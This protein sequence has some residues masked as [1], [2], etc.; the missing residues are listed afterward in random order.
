MYA[1]VA[2]LII[3]L[4]YG[5]ET[6][7]FRFSNKENSDEPAVFSVVLKSIVTSSLLFIILCTVFRIPIAN[8]LMYPN[9]S[10]YVVWFALIVG[11]DAISSIPLAR[12]RSKQKPVRFAMVNLT[13]VFVNIALNLF[14]IAYCKVQFDG[15]NSNWLIDT[16]YNPEIGVGY[17]FIA[18][19]VASIVKL[20]MLS[21]ELL[22]A[23]KSF[24]KKLLYSLMIYSSPLLVAGLAGMV[25]ETLD[26]ILLKYILIDSLGEKATMSQLGIYGACYKV[27]IIIT[28]FIQAF[29][30]AAEPFFFAQHKASPS[31]EIYARV[32]NYFVAVCTSIFLGVMLF[33]DLIK[34]FIP[35]PDYWVGLQ[36][37]P[38]LLMA[39][40]CLGIYFNQSIW[41]K[42]TDKTSFGAY[43][44]IGGAL[45]TITLNLLFIP[46]LGYVGSAWATL[47]VYASMVI[48]SY[49]F[50]QIHFP[51]PYNLL[52]VLGYIG[53]AFIV[54]Y[55]GTYL[56]ITFPQLH[57]IIA[58]V[59]VTAFMSTLFLIEKKTD[60]T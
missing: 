15:G 2:F 48:V 20:L 28:L 8:W 4:T 34:Y 12:L 56:Q 19:L 32:M 1:Y 51:I 21:P 16:F 44:A 25:N 57:W 41:Y 40:V 35:N 52:K 31:R 50:G 23:N 6:A 45:L 33:I 30:Y 10:E 42:M 37:V 14:F 49:I 58:T 22:A 17:V 36:V 26:R 55:I 13:N 39:N 54:Y 24:D 9:H 60:R 7:Y 27:S 38:I 59:G 46:S 3:L 29:R 53:S 5:M 43:I 47:I 18:N 11:F